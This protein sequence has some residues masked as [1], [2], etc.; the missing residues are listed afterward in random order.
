LDK[1]IVTAFLIIAGV[2][3]AVGVFNAIYP[4]VTESSQALISMQGRINE[5]LKSQIVII[6]AATG[7]GQTADVW[8]KNVGALSIRAIER[9]DVFFGLEGDFSSIPYGSGARYWTFT[10]ENDSQWNP[11]A[12]LKITIDYGQVLS[13][14]RYFVKIVLPN[15]ISDEYYFSK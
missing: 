4:A 2:V 10:L 9:C 8:V 14:G 11:R 12:T 15:G 3:V 7:G 6:H 1:T 5:R 13:N